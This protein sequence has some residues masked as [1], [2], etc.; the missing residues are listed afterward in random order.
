MAELLPILDNGHGF[1][2]P[3][4]RWSF[5]GVTFLEWKSNRETVKRVARKLD[6]LGITY[7]ILVP[8]DKDISLGER[9]RRVNALCAKYGKENCLLISVHSNASEKHNAKGISVWTSR[10]KTESDAYAE[11][12]WLEA[13]SHCGEARMLSDMSDG[14]HD[15]EAGF[16]MVKSTACPAVLVESF[17]YDYKPDFD[18]LMS[19]EGRENIAN[20]YVAS[21]QRCIALHSRK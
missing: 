19:E 18:Y 14:D 16:A 7:H 6:S 3:G 8:E 20:W 11:E 10:G 1:D 13:P 9:V 17:F 2:T 15:Y 4:K 5:D 21:I 12:W